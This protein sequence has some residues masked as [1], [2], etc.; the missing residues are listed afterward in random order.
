L[1]PDVA[2]ERKQREQLVTRHIAYREQVALAKS[3]AGIERW[4]CRH[5]CGHGH[6]LL[7]GDVTRGS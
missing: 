5:G 1:L 4:S 6:S 7:L 3:G 2:C